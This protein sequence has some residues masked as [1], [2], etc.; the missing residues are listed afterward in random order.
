MKEVK[1]KQ[2]SKEILD[3]SDK[4]AL[5]KCDFVF[6]NVDIEKNHYEND[7]FNQILAHYQQELSHTTILFR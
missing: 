6:E 3:P 5:S 7:L 2:S 4:G 1:V